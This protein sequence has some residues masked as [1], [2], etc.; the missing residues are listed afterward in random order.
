MPEIGRISFLI[1]IL[2]AILIGLLETIKPDILPVGALPWV[3]AILVITGLI[4]GYLN[5]DAS[6]ALIFIVAVVAVVLLGINW[7][8]AVPYL[9]RV[10]PILTRLATVL[11]PAAIVVGISQA[12]DKLRS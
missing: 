5:I 6:E 12:I 2:G 1:G 3:A 7:M 4:L 8:E 9:S 11:V 10:A